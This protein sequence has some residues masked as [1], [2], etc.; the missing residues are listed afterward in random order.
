MACA[1]RAGA[2]ALY[3]SQLG[4]NTPTGP[5]NDNLYQFDQATGVASVVGK[6]GIAQALDLASDWRPESPRLWAANVSDN[7]LY[8]LGTDGRATLVGSFGTGLDAIH[9]L[10]FDPATNRMFGTTGRSGDL[11]QID[12]GTGMATRL[13]H[14]TIPGITATFEIDALGCDAQGNLWGTVFSTFAFGGE[15]L[16]TIDPSSGV[17]TIR[18]ITAF[19]SVLDL[20][21]RPEDG[22]LFATSFGLASLYRVNPNTGAAT[23]IGHQAPVSLY[24]LAFVDLPE[25]GLVLQTVLGVVLLLRRRPRRPRGKRFE[26]LARK[27]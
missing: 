13:G 3:T 16:L 6:M 27:D 21:F 5:T 9:T 25:P 14:I 20:A 12:S 8:R 10:A 17:G 2:A 18:A 22:T 15:R 19:D 4:V 11:Y 23:P 7:S 24:G 1:G 26:V